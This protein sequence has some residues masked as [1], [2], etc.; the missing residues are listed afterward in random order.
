MN[1]RVDNLRWSKSGTL[2]AVGH[3]LSDNQE[4]GGPLCID[5]W[6]LAEVDPETMTARTLATKRSM[7]GFTGATVAIEAEDGFW[8]GTF[9]GDRIVFIPN[10]TR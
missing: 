3:R 4:C 1:F 2:L 6:E 9:D 10:G 8:L 7:N 5:E